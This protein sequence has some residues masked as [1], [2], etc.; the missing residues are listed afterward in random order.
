MIEKTLKEIDDKDFQKWW[1]HHPWC[2]VRVDNH[3]PVFHKNVLLMAVS[4]MTG[5]V[6]LWFVALNEM[7]QIQQYKNQK[8]TLTEKQ[9]KQK[10]TDGQLT[11]YETEI[12]L[13]QK[14]K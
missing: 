3:K 14:I 4:V 8:N 11:K 1:A 6:I 12:K 10:Y 13:L 2:P 5:M 7:S 9:L